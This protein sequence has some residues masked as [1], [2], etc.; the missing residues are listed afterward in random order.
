M[1]T[2]ESDRVVVRAIDPSDLEPL[3]EVNGDEEV[4]KYLPYR[5]WKT[6]DDAREWYDRMI[7]MQSRGLAIQLVVAEKPSRRAIGTCLLFRFDDKREHAE[8]GY[9]LGRAHWGQG[10]MREALATLMEGAARKL[11]IRTLDAVVD[12]RNEASW[13]LIERLGFRKVG[14]TGQLGQW[15]ASLGSRGSAATMP[16]ARRTRAGKRG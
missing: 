13:R 12:V 14:E 2:L 3:M 9:V 1:E 7:S 8:L 4:T 6:L 5:T 10:Y 11:G 15:R 16:A